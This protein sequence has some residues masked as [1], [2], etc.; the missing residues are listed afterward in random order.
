MSLIS[1][2]LI[3]IRKNQRLYQLARKLPG[4][5]GISLIASIKLFL[6]LPKKEYMSKINSYVLKD[7]PLTKVWLMNKLVILPKDPEFIHKVFTLKQTNVKPE[8]FY[9]SLLF[10]NGLAV[11]NG[12]DHKSH[13]KPLNKAFSTK[14]LERLPGMFDEKS[15]KFIKMMEVHVDGE[16]FEL[17]EYI[18]AYSLE[19]FAK[20]NMNID[21]ECFRSDL[22]DAY[23]R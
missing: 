23:E 16:E 6:T 9:R 15:R 10:K 20:S 18:G 8:I 14:M 5:D 2:F 22:L 7:S 17:T 12:S 4:H 11:L 1:Y 21:I 13:R 19:S 3:Y